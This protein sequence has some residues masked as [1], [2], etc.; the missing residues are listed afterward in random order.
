MNVRALVIRSSKSPQYLVERTTRQ[1]QQRGFDRSQI[2]HVTD[3]PG[4]AS[5]QLAG[6]KPGSRESNARNTPA[7]P[8]GLLLIH[9]GAWL[10][11]SQPP[12]SQKPGS[13]MPA[14]PSSL[15]EVDLPPASATGK[16]LIAVGAVR[17]CADWASGADPVPDRDSP[18]EL[19]HQWKA[20]LKSAGGDLQQ[21]AV[22]E[23]LKQGNRCCWIDPLLA[24]EFECRLH[25]SGLE[26]ALSH[27]FSHPEARI[28]HWQPLDVWH[29]VR[30]RVIQIITSLQRGGAERIAIDL[31]RC[32]LRNQSIT[33]LLIAVNAPSRSPFQS[34]PATI[35]LSD[36]N[37]RSE[38][39]RECAVMASEFAADV[40]HTHLLN[41]E[42]HQ[43][44]RQAGA[45]MLATIHNA[46]AGWQA[47]TD[48][49]SSRDVD[50]LVAC[51]Q[52][53]ERDLQLARIDVPTRTVWNGISLADF[54]VSAADRSEAR[55]RLLAHH[56]LPP[57][58]ILIAALANPRP[59]KRLE[60][61]P[62]ILRLTEQR[63]K[64]ADWIRPLHLL[65][66][67]EPSHGNAGAAESMAAIQQQIT[68][69]EFAD[70]IVWLGAVEDSRELLAATDLLVS[71][72]DYEGLSLAHLE[73]LSCGTT[74]VAT[75]VGGTEEIGDDQIGMHLVPLDASDQQFA[76]QLAH[77]I[78]HSTA[79]SQS[80][81][82]SFQRDFSL[83]RMRDGY[84][85][86]YQRLANQP[87]CI[88]PRG[89]LLVTNNFSTGGAQ[90][91]A[92]RLLHACHSRGI[93]V[94][95]A[96]LQEDTDKPTPGRQWLQ[97]HG[98]D[99]ACLP[100]AGVIDPLVALQPLLESIDREPPECVLL[101]NVIPEYKMLLADSLLTSRIYD[102]SPGEMNLQSLSRYFERPRP[103]LPYRHVR[104][105]ARR[106]HGA[107][108]KYSGEKRTVDET[109]G[110]PT[111]VIPN[112]VPIPPNRVLHQPKATIIFGT[113]ARI[114]PQKRLE[115][116][117]EAFRAIHPQLPAYELRI[118]GGVERGAEDYYSRLQQLAHGLP[119]C[120]SGEFPD[121]Q[122]FLVQLD[123]FVMISEPAGCPNASL[124]AMAVGL[125]VIATDVGGA[126][127]QIVDGVNGR[128]VAP[129]D[130]AAFGR[131]VRELANQLELRQQYGEESRQRAIELF[132]VQR[133]TDDYLKLLAMQT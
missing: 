24:T 72:S 62:G 90:S 71:P 70:R 49:F 5:P 66:A 73:A 29:D 50:L 41:R 55:R 82:A 21:P 97:S 4:S 102:V 95:A 81:A 46:R 86:L 18:P 9:A 47:G 56:Q 112:G 10:P 76:E 88:K 93:P 39:W 17:A 33:P 98:I 23:W 25:D 65:L 110:I 87:S 8:T 1:L 116:L 115:D 45:L 106:L 19:H 130:P 52:A 2:S 127:E 80:A 27:L 3:L 131:A 126:A 40:I 22:R 114:S 133:M 99:V 128:I 15:L 84:L 63:L 129:R 34:P 69:W 108:V 124:E 105:Y 125:P 7:H 48:Q 96:V 59:Q 79:T 103:G 107:V 42:D 64:S 51:S 89:L 30:L 104:E 53:V 43:C 31:H 109:F 26:D 28:I 120:W 74:V 94:R 68:H 75:R 122:A 14:S 113:A 16:P 37:S 111:V 119:V 121:T 67:G 44:L 6:A 38:R 101:W 61:L 20:M 54:Q 11:G 132:S 117:L 32:W 13:Q 83:V 35:A 91:S 12:G 58:S 57:D 92:R 36:L 118:A 78:L 77:A 123:V 100:R 85:R 60:R